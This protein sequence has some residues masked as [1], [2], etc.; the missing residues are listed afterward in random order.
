MCAAAT[1]K[2]ETA[3]KA[4]DLLRQVVA[5][6]YQDVEHLKRDSD[7][8]GLRQRDDFKKLLRELEGKAKAGG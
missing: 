8:D 2:E 1:K 5:K 3:A 6:G 7:L 4:V